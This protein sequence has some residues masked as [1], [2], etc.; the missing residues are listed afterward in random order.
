MELVA[1][2]P[3]R[4]G[5]RATSAART[6]RTCNGRAAVRLT[7]KEYKAVE[8]DRRRTFEEWENTRRRSK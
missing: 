6:C 4:E 7:A 3:M 8:R 1:I 5:D 2:P